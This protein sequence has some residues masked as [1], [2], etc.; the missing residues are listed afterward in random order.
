MVPQDLGCRIQCQR[1][2]GPDDAVDMIGAGAA[3]VE[4]NRGERSTLA[5]QLQF[6]TLAR[7]SYGN[8]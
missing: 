6:R 8:G 5:G 2:P 7:R 1:K 3:G 4:R